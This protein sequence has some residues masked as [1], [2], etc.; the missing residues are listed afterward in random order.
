M[1]SFFSTINPAYCFVLAAFLLAVFAISLVYFKKS[2]NVLFLLIGLVS[3]GLFYDTIITGL[4]YQLE[5]FGGYYF[6]GMMRHV[7]HG[8]LTPLIFIFVLKVCHDCNLLLAKK[9]TYIT[10]GF[11]V[12]VIIWAIVAVFTSPVDL[13]DYGGVIRHSI[14]KDNA[15]ILSALILKFLSFGTL[16]PMTIGAVVSIKY[17]KDYNI[18]IATV[19][20]LAFTMVGVI[21]DSDLTFLTSF[22]GEAFLVT[23]FFKYAYDQHIKVKA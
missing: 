18:L 15:F 23:F 14:D 21:I 16:I 9:Y 2:K 3:F 19:M 17:K 1:E 11:V 22:V 20:M 7:F 8:F 5:S 10:Y 13:I 12:V 4:G 6:I